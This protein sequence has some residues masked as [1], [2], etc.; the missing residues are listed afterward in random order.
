[1]GLAPLYQPLSNPAQSS[2]DYYSRCSKVETYKFG[3][4]QK[5]QE[6]KS[7]NEGE[8]S[9]QERTDTA[10]QQSPLDPNQIEAICGNPPQVNP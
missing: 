4:K 6:R 1:M 2:Y 9:S 7:E 5:I 10:D 8:Q 3:L